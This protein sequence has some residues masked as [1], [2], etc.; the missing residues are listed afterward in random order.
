ML[1]KTVCRSGR[2]RIRGR[3]FGGAMVCVL[4]P[5]T[6]MK[7]RDLWFVP[8]ED[9]GSPTDSSFLEPQKQKIKRDPPQVTT[10]MSWNKPR[11][12]RCPLVFGRPTTSELL[13]PFDSLVRMCVN[14]RG[15]TRKPGR[16]EPLPGQPFRLLYPFLSFD[17]A[18][19]RQLNA[20]ILHV[21]RSPRRDLLNSLHPQP[22]KL[23]RSNRTNP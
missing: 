18:T 13:R 5:T 16:D 19:D 11:V 22:S 21:I 17:S 20:E 12:V 4:R 2:K 9:W 14:R 1:S 6:Q 3:S 7:Y 23:F 10:L 15:S 8:T